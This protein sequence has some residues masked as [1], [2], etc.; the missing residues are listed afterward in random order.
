VD[1]PVWTFVRGSDRLEI[2]RDAV[3]DGVMLTMTGEGTPRSYFFRE[4]SRLDIFQRDME[5][6]LL[7]TGWSFVG[8]S[9]ERRIGGD[10][11]GWPRK[12]DD[13]RRW[14]TDGSTVKKQAKPKDEPRGARRERSTAD[15]SVVK[16]AGTR[17]K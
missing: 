13:R 15:D 17:S 2:S 16:P 1:N 4:A 14:W 6:L 7:K 5:T 11:R 9:P 3:D 12:A 10:R 8:F